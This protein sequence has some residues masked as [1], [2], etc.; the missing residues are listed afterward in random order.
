MQGTFLGCERCPAST[1]SHYEHSTKY[2]R[3]NQGPA[4]KGGAFDAFDAFGVFILCWFCAG[5]FSHVVRCVRE[6]WY[7][8][9]LKGSLEPSTFPTGLTK[10]NYRL[11]KR[12]AITV[13]A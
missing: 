9:R 13:Y 3:Q 6:G 1:T 2:E 10:G 12:R 5:R 7:E 11:I 4:R 8:R